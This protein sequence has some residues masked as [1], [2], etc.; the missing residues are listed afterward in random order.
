MRQFDLDGSA[1]SA[2]SAE[3]HRERRAAM[4]P[5]FSK[6]AIIQLEKDINKRLDQFY[7]H[8]ER[9]ERSKTEVVAL[10]AGFSALTSDI[11]QQYAFGFNSGNLEQ[12]DFNEHIRDGFISLF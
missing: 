8:L 5:F 12:D 6:Q 9:A 10:D 7:K 11:I 1:F 2:I 3:I 4:N